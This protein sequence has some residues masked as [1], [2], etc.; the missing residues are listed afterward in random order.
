MYFEK[1]R[2]AFINARFD[3]RFWFVFALNVILGLIIAAIIAF[4]A[5]SLF[6]FFTSNLDKIITPENVN[7]AGKL[8]DSM[9]ELLVLRF[10]LIIILLV[11]LIL[12]IFW[13]FNGIML[14]VLVRENFDLSF[15][16][17][18]IS[19]IIICL[20]ASFIVFLL[21]SN[22]PEKWGV[23]KYIIFFIWIHLLGV[24]LI[25]FSKTNALFNGFLNGF[26]RGI[27]IW[28]FILPYLFCLVILAVG[29]GIIYFVSQFF[30]PSISASGLEDAV[31][32]LLAMDLARLLKILAIFFIILLLIWSF[33]CS[34]VSVFFAE[35]VLQCLGQGGQSKEKGSEKQA[36]QRKIK[37]R[38][39]KDF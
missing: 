34:Y 8:I 31:T 26:L 28:E 29:A 3:R 19:F 16:F 20:V 12:I 2:E 22:I 18:L 13:F 5:Y 25:S 27:R 38:L 6:S 1:L 14:R 17:K 35:F 23:L 21:V 9:I 33:I 32:K 37:T 39:K 4:L 10:I 36:E 30:I 15:H 24:S 11:A 7:N